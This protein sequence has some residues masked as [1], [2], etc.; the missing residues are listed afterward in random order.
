M[1][2][3]IDNYL[4][5][6]CT[7]NEWRF[8]FGDYY[9]ALRPFLKETAQQAPVWCCPER[10]YKQEVISA[11]EDY[12]AISPDYEAQ[13][14]LE[15]NNIPVDA[16]QMWEFC[17]FTLAHHLCDGFGLQADPK[18]MG[19]GILRLGTLSHRTDRLPAFLLTCAGRNYLAKAQT[20][21]ASH[22]GSCLFYSPR[23]CPDTS[24]WLRKKQHAYFSLVDLLVTPRLTVSPVYR[25]KLQTFTAS[26]PSVAYQPNP[27]IQIFQDYKRIRFPDGSE[28]NLAKAHKRRA[29]VR[30]ICNW[31]K[32]SGYALF[33]V[34]VVR[35][36]YNKQYPDKLW[37]SDRIR[38]DLFK[39]NIEDFDRLF[40]TVDAA[41]GRYRLKI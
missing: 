12:T 23:Y 1:L 28:I 20:I 13:P 40:E 30:F 29:V 21:S 25:Q 3:R 37:D 39:R 36:E 41:N 9:S 35:E 6:A 16:L 27:D 2:E 22:S 24:D 10:G 5:I 33:D 8:L 38:E 19:P 17:P 34:E 18:P 11:G 31:V 14:E 32:Q 7:P 26:L 4:G 15:V